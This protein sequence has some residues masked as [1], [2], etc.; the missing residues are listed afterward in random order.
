MK[1]NV[2]K[3][4][5]AILL[6]FVSVL[7][8]WAVTIPEVGYGSDFSHFGT[9]SDDNAIEIYSGTL[10]SAS[11]NVL[12]G[13][14][15]CCTLAFNGVSPQDAAQEFI[16]AGLGEDDLSTKLI[17]VMTECRSKGCSLGDA[18]AYATEFR[19]A[20][21]F[22]LGDQTAPVSTDVALMALFAGAYL[23]FALWRK[24]RSMAKI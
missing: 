16:D 23:A 20:T 1:K 5:T 18:E 11:V 22:G 24:K 19:V 12:S 8:L 6:P 15:D 13:T 9:G 14:S 4:F 17:E 3:V 7:S 2:I 21:G 10:R